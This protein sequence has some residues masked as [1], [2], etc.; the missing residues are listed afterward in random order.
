MT[1]PEQVINADE[2]IVEALHGHLRDQRPVLLYNTFHGV[3]ISYEAQVVLVNPTF[4]GLSVHPYQAVCIKRERRTYIESKAIDGLIRGI[5]TLIDFKN[6]VVMLT[7]LK[8]VP[9][10]TRD[11]QHSRISPTKEVTVELSSDLGIAQTGQM[12]TL[13]VL[14]GNTLRMAISLPVDSVYAHLDA[15]ELIFKLPGQSGLIQVNGVV[16]GFTKR[17]NHQEM[18]LE[19]EGNATLQDEVSILAYVAQQE[20]AQMATLDQ[21]FKKLRKRKKT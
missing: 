14:G 4:V 12:L 5:P 17:R 2:R 10:K 13:S 3:A 21:Q 16:R 19:V 20:D 18:R 8:S 11:K 7:Q 6:Q 9:Q 1:K 15:V